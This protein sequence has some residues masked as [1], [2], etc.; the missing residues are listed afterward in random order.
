MRFTKLPIY[1][2]RWG[3][4]D[5]DGDFTL[6]FEYK[7]NDIVTENDLYTIKNEINSL[8]NKKKDTYTFY[9]YKKY[10]KK[11]ISCLC[12]SKEENMYMWSTIPY[13]KLKKNLG[14]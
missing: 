11:N 10:T 8:S 1:G 9:I 5:E 2:I 6:L 14:I 7:S 4:V 12:L 3:L 13:S